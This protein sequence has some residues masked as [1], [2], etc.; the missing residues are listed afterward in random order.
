MSRYFAVPKGWYE[1]EPD[2]WPSQ[3]Q[4]PM[5]VYPSDPVATG[6]VDEHGNM[7]MRGQNKIGFIR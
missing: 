2:T 1:Y 6:L 7:I 3:P 5:T 4:Q